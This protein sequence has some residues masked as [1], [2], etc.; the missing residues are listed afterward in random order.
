[1]RNDKTE[2]LKKFRLRFLYWYRGIGYLLIKNQSP[3]EQE[4]K[5]RER[6]KT[7]PQI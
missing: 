2:T 7:V 5:N 4:Q 3:M 6:Y 1:M